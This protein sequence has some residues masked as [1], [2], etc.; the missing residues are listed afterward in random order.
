MEQEKDNGIDGYLNNIP[1]LWQRESDF[2]TTT[3][4]YSVAKEADDP[5]KVLNKDFRTVIAFKNKGDFSMK[6]FPFAFPENAK[7]DKELVA[8]IIELEGDALTDKYNTK[9]VLGPVGSL[10]CGTYMRDGRK[11]S[12]H[13]LSKLSKLPNRPMQGRKHLSAEAEIVRKDGTGG[14]RERSKM[15]ILVPE[16]LRKD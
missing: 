5:N 8:R 11:Y 15:R 16:H 9:F 12:L 10:A 6:T 13:D 7:H 4:S 2:D 3:G 14:K 1:N